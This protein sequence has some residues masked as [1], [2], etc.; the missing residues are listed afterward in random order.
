MFAGKNAIITGA[1]RGIGEAIFRLFSENHANIWC[2]IRTLTPEFQK[3][4]TELSEKYNIWIEPV[5]ADLSDRDSIK[6]AMDTIGTTNRPIDILVNNA[7]INYRGSFLMTPISDMEKL[8][9]V[10]FY[11]PIQLMQLTAKK[12]LRKKSGV[13]INVGSVS[14]LEHNTGNFAYASSKAA[15]LWATQTISRELAAYNIRVNAV[16]PGLTDTAINE[17]NEQVINEEVLPV[18]NIKR[19]GTVDEIARAVLFLA[20]ENSSFVSGQILRVDGGRFHG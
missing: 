15:I 16:A 17:G 12:M 10:N 19:K 9:Q 13:I 20:S 18:M 4:M 7:G 5:L 6:A 8:F 3:E 14:G 1:N 11:A 2:L